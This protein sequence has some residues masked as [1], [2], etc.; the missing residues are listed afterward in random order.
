MIELD[1]WNLG[2]THVEVPPWFNLIYGI[3]AV[4]EVVSP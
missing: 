1:L 4:P 3:F 2:S